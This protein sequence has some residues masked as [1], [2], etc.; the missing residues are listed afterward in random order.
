M[1]DE[2]SNGIICISNN[3]VYKCPLKLN[4]DYK[5]IMLGMFY[6][7]FN[8]KTNNLFLIK[9]L[10]NQI[11][12]VN[13]EIKAGRLASYYGYVMFELKKNNLNIFLPEFF[14]EFQLIRTLDIIVQK[15]DNNFSLYTEVDGFYNDLKDV[16]AYIMYRFISG[17]YSDLCFDAEN[18]YDGYSLDRKARAIKHM[19]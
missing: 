15:E 10:K 5:H 8:M 14:N 4:D 18:N 7:D 11:A 2:I 6:D 16:P 3:F 19:K 13:D 9:I 1:E 17:K 12:N